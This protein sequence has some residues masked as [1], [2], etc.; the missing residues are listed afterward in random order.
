MPTDYK[1]TLNLPETSFP[2]RANLP[3][4]EPQILA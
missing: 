3:V 4:R 1:A 2:M